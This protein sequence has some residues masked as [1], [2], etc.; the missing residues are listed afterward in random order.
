M[1]EELKTLLE[2][3]YQKAFSWY[4]QKEKEFFGAFN[5]GK[6]DWISAQKEMVTAWKKVD[7]IIQEIIQLKNKSLI[8]VSKISKQKNRK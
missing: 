4:N 5:S 6:G 8:K 1:K 2:A 7:E 3:K